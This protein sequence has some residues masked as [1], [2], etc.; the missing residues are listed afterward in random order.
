MGH[1]ARKGFNMLKTLRFSVVQFVLFSVGGLKAMTSSSLDAILILHS[2][3]G[4][5]ILFS[6]FESISFRD[7]L[8]TGEDTIR[9]PKRHVMFLKRDSAV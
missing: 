1:L 7:T 4:I 6:C 3:A 9:I 5:N 8:N 2:P